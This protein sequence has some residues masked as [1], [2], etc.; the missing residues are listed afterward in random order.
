[1]YLPTVSIDTI[2]SILRSIE[3]DELIGIPMR[4]RHT[5]FFTNLQ[6]ENEDLALMCATQCV[7][8]QSEEERLAFLGGV[9]VSLALVDSQL[10]SNE[11]EAL[12]DVCD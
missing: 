8:F 10:E 11:L 1:M 9:F 2:S 5:E 3:N 6:K 4:N 7:K 12:Y